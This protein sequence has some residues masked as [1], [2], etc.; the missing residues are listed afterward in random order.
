MST[1]LPLKLAALFVVMWNSSLI[2]SHLDPCSL[3][4]DAY[5]LFLIMKVPEIITLLCYLIFSSEV[6]FVNIEDLFLILS[7]FSVKICYKKM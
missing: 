6:D 3:F 4:L 7:K 2:V 1:P 5:I